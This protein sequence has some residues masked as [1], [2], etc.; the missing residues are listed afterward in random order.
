MLCSAT[1]NTLQ[2]W[3]AVIDSGD[4]MVT[5]AARVPMAEE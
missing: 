4:L 5:L 1:R 3:R 2:A